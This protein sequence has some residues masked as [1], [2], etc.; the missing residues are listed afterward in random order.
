RPVPQMSAPAPRDR[1]SGCRHG[2][3]CGVASPCREPL[4]EGPLHA[5]AQPPALE[6]TD[7]AAPAIWCPAALGRAASRPADRNE[8]TL[9]LP[10]PSPPLY[11]S[12]PPSSRPTGALPPCGL[13][14]P[15]VALMT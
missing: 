6:P 11:A 7:A 12:P 14:F 9:P 3:V 8:L 10:Y 13:P 5:A 1:Q 2:A 15:P 4:S